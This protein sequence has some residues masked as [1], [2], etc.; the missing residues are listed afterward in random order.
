ML[1]IYAHQAG[2]QRRVNRQI[3]AVEERHPMALQTEQMAL[4]RK[5]SGIWHQFI[6]GSSDGLDGEAAGTQPGS[7]PTGFTAVPP[8]SAAPAACQ[9]ASG[10]P[11][12]PPFPNQHEHRALPWAPLVYYPRWR[13]ITCASCQEAVWP[14]RLLEHLASKH[15]YTAT[16]EDRFLVEQ[17]SAQDVLH[18][19]Q[20]LRESDLVQPFPELVRGGE[21]T[22]FA[23]CFHDCQP[24][25]LRRTQRA[26]YRH[27]SLEHGVHTYKAQ[28]RFIVP[29][30]V[31]SLLPGSYIF[32]II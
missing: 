2:H 30:Q 20:Q 21:E 3:Y 18:L 17:L 14:T 16:A 27:V 6:L 4:F 9:R 22:G 1:N 15:G 29:V 31:Q 10:G 24:P 23:C 19:W 11:C 13:M 25:V 32:R 12:P 8:P 7:P 28:A 26:A 5:A